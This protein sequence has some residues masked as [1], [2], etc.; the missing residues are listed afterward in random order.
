MSNKKEKMSLIEACEFA[1]QVTVPNDLKESIK[2]SSGTS[3]KLLNPILFTS[4]LFEPIFEFDI[5]LLIFLL[6]VPIFIILL[7]NDCSNPDFS[8]YKVI[9]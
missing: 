3:S 4:L 8:N 7:F 2:L 5:L 1:P 9:K 6:G